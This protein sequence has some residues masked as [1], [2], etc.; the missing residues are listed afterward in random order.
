[1]AGFAGLEAYYGSAASGLG[2]AR[3]FAAWD[4]HRAVAEAVDSLGDDLLVLDVGCGAGPVARRLAERHRFVGADIASEPL[5]EFA[6]FGLAV[7]ADAVSLPFRD[8][9]FNVVL[10]TQTLYHLPVDAALG[11]MARVT[12]PD[13]HLV[14]Q[15]DM[16]HDFSLWPQ[17]AY[18]AIRRRL[19]GRFRLTYATGRSRWRSVRRAIERAGF[20]PVRRVAL[21]F[22]SGPLYTPTLARRLAAVATELPGVAS[23]QL[24]VAVRR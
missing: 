12:R 6:R 18:W 1:M 11:E 23:Q 3:R 5:A 2:P 10:C 4:R 8:Q 17:L 21:E 14:L 20:E 9:T 15:Q 24:V 22:P 19:P 7:L 13:G 16:L